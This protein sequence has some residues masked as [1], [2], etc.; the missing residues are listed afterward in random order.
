MQNSMRDFRK[1]IMAVT[2]VMA[3]VTVGCTD[4]E[5]SIGVELTP[6]GSNMQIGQLEFAGGLASSG[7]RILSTRLFKSDRINSASQSTAILGVQYTE[8]FGERRSGFF[9][10]YT[11]A[12]SI[13]EDDVFGYEPFLDSMV[14]M[15]SLNS[16]SGDTTK[17]CTYEVYEVID[18]SFLVN[19]A[20][21]VY[22]VDFDIFS[23]GALSDEP[24]FEFV[25]P[26][27]DNDVYVSKT[28]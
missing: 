19:K 28:S 7:E 24:L 3:V 20:D 21:T 17:M 8:E 6:D 11:P 10:Q 2:L 4:I 1:L 25:Y 5:D 14:F 13:D 27:P 22:N 26:D 23:V 18:D 16:F 12:Y 15:I 9:S